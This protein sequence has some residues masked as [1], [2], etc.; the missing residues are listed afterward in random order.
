MSEPSTSPLPYRVS[1]SEH[2][3][4]Q[5]LDLISR[6]R[7]AGLGQQALAAV[8]EIDKRLRI[9][10]QFGQPLRDLKLKPSQLWIATVPPVDREVRPER[11]KAPRDGV[12]P[13]LSDVRAPPR[14]VVCGGHLPRYPQ[15]EDPAK[16][17]VEPVADY[18]IVVK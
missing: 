14:T 6:A 4:N 11:G 16:V 7:D 17:F 8:K 15:G 2:V 18:I 13:I 10:P 9:Y 1:Y 3:R 5:L 12:Y